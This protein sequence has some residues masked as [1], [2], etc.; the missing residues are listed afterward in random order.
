MSAKVCGEV[1]TGVVVESDELEAKDYQDAIRVLDACNLSGVLHS[2]AQKQD[3]IRRDSQRKGI[4][5]A[6][7]PINKLFAAK[8]VELCEMGFA[9]TEMFGEAFAACEEAAS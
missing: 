2:W 8:V 9:D 3:K 5:Y 7:H 4:S 1:L 6:T